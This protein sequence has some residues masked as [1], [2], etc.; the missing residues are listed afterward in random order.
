MN[1]ELLF[2]IIFQLLRLASFFLVLYWL[3]DLSKEV[4]SLMRRVR[5]LE[6][7]Q[8]NNNAFDSAVIEKM[9][10]EIVNKEDNPLRMRQ[11]QPITGKRRPS[12]DF[13]GE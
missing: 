13:K 8:N 9:I 2:S 5:K 12:S 10:S 7:E 4:L 1:W 3:N 11:S 6:S